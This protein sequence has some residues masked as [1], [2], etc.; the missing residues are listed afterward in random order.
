MALEVARKR[1]QRELCRLFERRGSAGVEIAVC[2]VFQ[3]FELREELQDAQRRV[4][5]FDGEGGAVAIGFLADVKKRL[6]AMGPAG[7]L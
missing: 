1:L 7:A 5:G 2:L 3:L 4:V 6:E